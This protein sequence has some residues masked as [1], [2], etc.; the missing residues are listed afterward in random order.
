MC[1]EVSAGNSEWGLFDKYEWDLV[2]LR[3]KIRNTFCNK[4]INDNIVIID[5]DEFTLGKKEE[6]GQWPFPRSYYAELVKSLKEDG[7]KVV[8]LDILLSEPDRTDV[9]NDLIF[10]VA[11][12]ETNN[13][14]LPME[15]SNQSLPFN[16]FKQT[17]NIIEISKAVLPL[18]E[19]RETCSLT[20][21]VDMSPESDGIFRKVNLKKYYHDKEFMYFSLAIATY[22]LNVKPDELNISSDNMGK[23][24]INY[25]G[26]YKTFTYIPF[27]EVYKKTYRKNNKNFFKD[28]YVIIGSSAPGLGD[29]KATPVSTLLPGVEI[30]ATALNT[31][32][33][34]D[35]ITQSSFPLNC[36]LII[37]GTFITAGLLSGF[38]PLWGTLLCLSTEVI[39]ILI[40]F[41]LFINKNFLLTTVP[42]CTVIG[43]CYMS[44]ISY[45]LITEERQKRKLKNIFQRYVSPQV[46]NLIVNSSDRPVLGG[47][48][49]KMTVLFS[50]IRNFTP[51]SEKLQPEE[52]V[53][54]LNEY[55]TSM[56]EIIFKYDGTIDKFIG[57]C[58]MAFWGAPIHHR[59]DALRAV[60]SALGM[61][62][63][64]EELQEKW[65]KEGKPPFAV[66]IGINT[67]EVVV[68]NIGSPER[69][70]YTTIG[71]EVNLASRLQSIA[72]EGQIFI[73]NST[74]REVCEEIEAKEITP[75]KV[76]GKSEPVILYEVTGIKEHND[77]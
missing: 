62:R 41:M 26:G 4:K 73:S 54:V 33:N 63:K 44:I 25:Q 52:V 53:N 28:K 74:Y 8:C 19:F 32:L 9:N 58:I 69:M 5:I 64:L 29:L 48:R 49:K 24:F 20:G 30:Q 16:S 76:K 51:M 46:V 57:D 27:Y 12:K 10:A 36:I 68:G 47:E 66:G 15:F 42:I 45:R 59:D 11:M 14:I 60:K 61:K 40:S 43:T 21:F 22:I 23:M 71:D 6:I 65:K 7:A 37:A 77:K 1:I 70:E 35:Y 31:I 2:D 38:S 13:V 18:K 75:V 3:F 56:A 34:R 50:D 72:K 55:F 17:D 39:I 67:G